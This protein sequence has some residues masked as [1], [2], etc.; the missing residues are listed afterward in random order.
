MGLPAN[1]SPRYWTLDVLRG[2]CSLAVFG[3]HW[4]LGSS[5]IPAGA[6]ARGVQRVL[7]LV[8]EGFALL[9]WPT[10]GQ[11]PAV[12]CFFV[13]SGFCVHGP[14]ER[15]LAQ[16]GPPVSWRDYFVRRAQRI[17]PVYWAAALLGL[18]VV[19]AQH[20]RPVADP[21]IG[22]HTMGTPAQ[23]AARMLGYAGLWP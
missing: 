5:F 10:G 20:W 23:F 8:N 15:R 1:H 19:A 18:I 16:P 7:L 11:H 9:T 3:T 14:F 2:L 12:I 4:V 22:L 6:V 17:M 21:V 13:L